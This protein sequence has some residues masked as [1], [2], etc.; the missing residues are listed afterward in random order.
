LDVAAPTL[1]PPA[2]ERLK[3]WSLRTNLLGRAAKGLLAAAFLGCVVQAVIAAVAL[4]RLIRLDLA[5]DASMSTQPG[6]SGSIWAS[7][8]LA[9]TLWAA[10]A[11]AL[12][13]AAVLVPLRPGTR[14][15]K[16]AYLSATSVLSGCVLQMI[17]DF[18]I[19]QRGYVYDDQRSYDDLAAQFH[20]D[21]FHDLGYR[22][23]LEAADDLAATVAFLFIVAL[24]A[25]GIHLFFVAVAHAEATGYDRASYHARL[26]STPSTPPAPLLDEVLAYCAAHPYQGDPLSWRDIHFRKDIDPDAATGF[27]MHVVGEV[28]DAIAVSFPLLNGHLFPT[29]RWDGTHLMLDVVGGPLVYQPVYADDD[30]QLVVFHRV[31]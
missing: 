10:T 31:S 29:R 17:T 26:S 1:L 23:Y 16:R 5:V 13:G 27:T 15:A 24:V 8:W 18:V 12:A 21:R 4:P 19:Y 22:W 7:P 30:R 25:T 20:A 14:F 6:Q 28:P 3:R 2:V 11:L 9:S